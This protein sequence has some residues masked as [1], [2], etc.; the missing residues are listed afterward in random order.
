MQNFA[1]VEGKKTIEIAA[2]KAKINQLATGF[3]EV[4]Y[5]SNIVAKR[6][7]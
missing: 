7:I 3:L 5:I 1:Q 2:Q 6:E 4:A